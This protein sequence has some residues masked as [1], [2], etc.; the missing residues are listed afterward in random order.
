[1][2][3]LQTQSIARAKQLKEQLGGT[4]FSFPLEEDNP[5]SSYAIVMCVEDQYFPYPD[6]CDIS[7]AA[8]GIFILLEEM[9]KSGMDAD[10]QR[11]VRMI[12]HQAQMDAPST[13]MRKLKKENISKPFLSEGKDFKKGIEGEDEQISARGLLKISYLQMVEEKNPKASQFMEHYYQLLAMRK[14]GKTAAAIRQEVRKMTKDQV[15]GWLEQTFE[16]YIHN[17]IEVMSFLDILK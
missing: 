14:Y 4:I 7:E 5:F 12:S 2:N 3:N 11:N 6:A 16:K 17:D 9:K 15:L 8:S 13:V 10:Y 1:M